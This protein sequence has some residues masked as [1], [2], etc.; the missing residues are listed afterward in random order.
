MKISL[1]VTC[2]GD[3]FFPEAAVATVTVLERLGHQVIAPSTQTCCGQMHTNT[4]YAEAG[5][6]LEHK[7]IT[8]FA[9]AEVIVAAS[10]SCVAHLRA[11]RSNPAT[12]AHLR[13]VGHER[14][15]AATGGGRARSAPFGRHL[16]P[17][18]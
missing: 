4:G 1:F 5:K 18:A 2:L 12:R 6:A 7:V 13:P 16:R 15:R 8:D 3:M 11:S 17:N 9:G 10:G 14:H